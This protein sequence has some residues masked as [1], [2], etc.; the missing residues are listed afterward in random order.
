VSKKNNNTRRLKHVFDQQA[1]ELNGEKLLVCPICLRVFT[2]IDIRPDASGKRVLSIEHA[3]QR[4]HR[5]P[6]V[7]RCLTCR[8]C[9]N[10]CA[11]EAKTGKLN[12]IRTA[13]S[14]A[15]P[16]RSIPR[17]LKATEHGLLV[18]EHL[19]R[20]VHGKMVGKG[21]LRPN[22]APT[23]FSTTSTIET[24]VEL[25]TAYLIAFARLGYA[26][27]FT[28]ALN[29]VR[30]AILNGT[31]LRSCKSVLASKEAFHLPNEIFMIEANGIPCAIVSLPP[32]HPVDDPSDDHLVI[33][34]RPGSPMNLYETLGFDSELSL[35]TANVRVEPTDGSYDFPPEREVQ[36]HWDYPCGESHPITQNPFSLVE[37]ECP[38]HGHERVIEILE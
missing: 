31:P 14:F 20:H 37:R 8:T 17:P 19:Q 21:L 7:E 24:L 6:A 9:N 36:R 10:E 34:P 1:L 11:F 15:L 32:S 18:Q 27:I 26:F 3:P 22:A 2:E 5:S 33:L 28:P 13:D 35:G 16:L 38:T 25:K 23:R 4:M 29:I 30:Q 12:R